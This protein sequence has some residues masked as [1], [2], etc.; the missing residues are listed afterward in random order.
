MKR[1]DKNIGNIKGGLAETGSCKCQEK[2]TPARKQK[3]IKIAIDFLREKLRKGEI[4]QE[5]FKQELEKI[6]NK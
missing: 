5:I 6:Y 4:T 1:I 2:T 3:K